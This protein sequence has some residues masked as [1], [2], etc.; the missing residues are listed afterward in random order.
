MAKTPYF[1]NVAIGTKKRRH[2]RKT[3]QNTKNVYSSNKGKNYNTGDYTLDRT[4]GYDNLSKNEE[5]KRGR[6]KKS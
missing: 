2:V 1:D 6:N 5:E 4:K 3:K